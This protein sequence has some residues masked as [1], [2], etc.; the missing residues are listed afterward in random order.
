VT[1][2]LSDWLEADGKELIQGS[3]GWFCGFLNPLD[4]EFGNGFKLGAK[5]TDFARIIAPAYL[6]CAGILPVAIEQILYRTIVFRW[7]H[8]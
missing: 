5:R 7:Y 1:V 8:L 2:R 4:Y 3:E 6:G